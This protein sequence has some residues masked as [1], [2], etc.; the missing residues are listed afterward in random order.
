M[1][2]LIRK[3]H[4][5]DPRA[6]HHHQTVDL[7]LD[8]GVIALVGQDLDIEAAEV[9]EV[10]GLHAMPGGLDVGAWVGDPGFEQREDFDSLSKAAAAGG[11]TEVAVWPNTLPVVD[12]KAEVAYVA[13]QGERL[14]VAFHPIGALT[15]G[16]EGT[17]ITEMRDMR[18]AGALAFSD[19]L[20]P[21]RHAGV[22]LRA[23]QYVLPFEG[24]V[25]NQ[26]FDDSV[27]P[28]GQMHEG[29]VSTLLGLKGM[30]PLAETLMVQRD[31]DILRYTGSRLLLHGISC[32]ESVELVRRAKN[33]GLRVYASVPLMNLLFTEDDLA[34]F[35]TRF[36]V[37]P[38]LRTAADRA[39]LI[40]G[41]RDGTID[42]VTSNHLPEEAEHKEREFAFAAFGASTIQHVWHG[43]RQAGFSLEEIAEL[44]AHRPRQVLGLPT[45]VIDTGAPA[46]LTLFTPGTRW[47]FGES[48]NR[49]RSTNDPF[50]DRPK[51]GMI[52]G[53]ARNGF[54]VWID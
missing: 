50:L 25:I 48:H 22:L 42:L 28:N 53:I 13:R 9:L 23:M 34:S 41:L 11:F 27:A 33:E 24:L 32:A 19:G 18:E 30:P 3:V 15:K 6:P 54:F 2:R 17:T 36:K 7:L 1:L 46:N 38:P 14:P 47:T 4:V 44:M 31:I 39:A 40:E 21:V 20:Q 5:I 26:P 51:E 35:D 49:S 37:V 10:E 16:C 29:R 52:R 45:P 8:D 43:L 12:G